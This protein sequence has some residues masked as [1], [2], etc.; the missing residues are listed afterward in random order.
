M[1]GLDPSR[2]GPFVPPG[3][4]VGVTGATGL[5]GGRLVERLAEQ[6][7]VVTCFVR[8][9]GPSPGVRTSKA[10]IVPLNLADPAAVRAGLLGIELVFHCAYDFSDTRWNL[11]ALRALISACRTNRCL[12]LVHLSSFVVYR[13]PHEGELTEESP[14]ETSTSGY[15]NTKRQLEAELLRA[16][17]NDGLPAT[18]LQP[19]IVYGPRSRP[20]TDDPADMLRYGTVI[21]PD[22][23]SGVCNA[24]YVDDVVSA[25]ILAAQE[26]RA[27]GQ[28]FLISGPEPVTWGQFYEAIAWAVGANG[29]QYRPAQDIARQTRRFRKVLRLAVDPVRALQRVA[30]IEACRKALQAGLS[31]LPRS[32]RDRTQQQLFGPVTRRRGQI[33]IPDPRFIESRA[34]IGSGKARRELGYVPQFD[35]A[36][37]M[38]LTTRYLREE[39]EKIKGYFSGLDALGSGH[40]LA[41][42]TARAPPGNPN[43]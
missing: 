5:I 2:T 38:Q 36:S 24:V 35:F 11:D 41:S 29:P 21:L 40:Y 25:M 33:H 31:L 12:R 28:R 18:I 16:V 20:W 8:N 10:R 23:G 7:A 22:S 42:G 9:T 17:H 4:T 30:Q 39:R 27:V 14:Q 3:T 15:A 13:I 6:G 34:T 1:R 19:T 37:G 32:L 43:E 26:P